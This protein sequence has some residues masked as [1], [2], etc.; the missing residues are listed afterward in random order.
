MIPPE[1]PERTSATG[2]SRAFSGLMTPPFERRI[3]EL[4]DAAA[5]ALLLELRHVVVHQR[6]QVGVEHRRRGALVLAPAR[7]HLVRERDAARPGQ[8][9]SISSRVRSSCSGLT[10]EKR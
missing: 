4:V 5:L 7:Q 2:C 9:S 6:L 1:G 3:E 8:S 10:N